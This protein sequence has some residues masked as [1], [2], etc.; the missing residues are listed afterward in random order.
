MRKQIELCLG[1]GLVGI[2]ALAVVGCGSKAPT[3]IQPME[4]ASDAGHRAIEKYDANKDGVLDYNELAKAPGLRSGLARIKK[5]GTFRGPKPSESQLKDLKIS[6]DEIDAR[7]KEWKEHGSGRITVSCRVFRKKG[8]AKPQPIADAEV[9]FVPEDFL[10]PGLT[11]G[12]GTT[13]KG[14][15]AGIAQPSRGGD[16]PAIGVCPGFYSV[17]ITK[18]NE[19]PAKYNTE[20][21]LGVEISGDS[22]ALQAGGPKFELEY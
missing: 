10:G 13:D 22:D 15:V 20:T 6:A 1:L 9:Q 17:K 8:G 12:T 16:D 7:I 4:V 18:G 2:V 5:L 11:T 3:A 21:T 19:I 14:G